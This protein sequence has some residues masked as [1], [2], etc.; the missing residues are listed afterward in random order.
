MTATLLEPFF[1][2]YL[3]TVAGNYMGNL[4]VLP[5]HA[6]ILLKSVVLVTTRDVLL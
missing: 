2:S 1:L 3:F 6:D 5:G 4:F